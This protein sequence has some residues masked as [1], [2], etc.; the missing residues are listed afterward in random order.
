M[1]KD[2]QEWKTRRDR[3]DVKLKKAGWDV[4][5]RTKVLEEVDTK[6]SVFPHDI[7]HQKDTL[8]EEE[9]EKAYADYILLDNRGMPLA[10]VEAKKAYKDPRIG[11]KQAEMYVDDIK[12][13]LESKKDVLIFYTNGIDIWYWNKG[14]ETPRLVSGFYSQDDLMRVRFQNVSAENFLDVQPREE[15]I[16]RPYQLEA[17]QRVIE[18]M[19]RGK[20]RFLI[21]QATG[22]GKTRVA[23]ALI[24]VMIRAK[25]AKRILFLTDRTELNDQA[26]DEN[27][28][29][30]FPSESKQKV[31]SSTV[32]QDSRIYAATLQTMKNNYQ[33]FSVGFFDLIIS[34]EAHRSVYD[35][36]GSVF[37]YFDAKLIGLTATPADYVDHYTYEKFDCEKNV[38][39]FSFDY[40]QAVPK[41]LA[42]YAVWQAQT[43]IQRDGIDANAL[44]PEELRRL[45]VDE[46]LDPDDVNWTGSDLERKITVKSTIKAMIREF[47]DNCYEDNAGL[48]AK[49]IFFPVSIAHARRIEECFDEMYPEHHGELVSVIT[50]DNPR[51]KQMVKDF[52]KK[53][54]PRIA[55]SVGILDTGVDIPEVCNLAFMRPIR[56]GIRF[57]QML[58]RGTRHE[59]ICDHRDWLPNGKKESFL[60]FDYWQN[61]EEHKLHPTGPKMYKT[62]AI[63]TKIFLNRLK[64]YRK[65]FDR[66]ETENLE[67]IKQKIR[68]D[69]DNLDKESLTIQKNEPSIEITKEPSFWGGVGRDPIDFLKKEIAPLMKYRE[70]V[71]LP[72]QTFVHN[73]EKYLLVK[74]EHDEDPDWWKQPT[75][76]QIRDRI[77]DDV[78]K[79]PVNMNE[80]LPKADIIESV[81]NPEFWTDTKT[82]DIFRMT[83]ELRALMKH[84][85]TEAQKIIEIVAD[86]QIVERLPIIYGPDMKEERVEVYQ[87]KVE[88]RVRELADSH[89]VIQKIKTNQALTEK[90]IESLAEALNAPELFI[91]EEILGRIYRRPTG[92]VVEFIKHILGIE[93][94]KEPQELIDEAFRGF[95][96]THTLS[97][98]QL[99]F[100]QILQTYFERKRHVEKGDL[101]EFPFANMGSAW[102]TP[103]FK[104]GDVD[105]MLQMCTI[106]EKEVFEKR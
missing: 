70:G 66:N 75:A 23:M 58:G 105:N 56:S 72:E 101:Y 69:I 7:K 49:T 44:T 65:F 46:G 22:T 26:F 42:R 53:S 99:K 37:E 83:E 68:T 96:I 21:V 45:L 18:G 20:R 1:S 36:L 97:A 29:N 67:V 91:S 89:P 30:F 94:L 98:D 28:V 41:Y 2:E 85:R 59:S 55:I 106:L 52:K 104:E 24:D 17:V 78:L 16:N 88:R 80:V 4:K 31:Y 102:P 84:K 39:T 33:D 82:E 25:R 43:G 47:M 10:V 81:K 92:E 103:S 86:D 51:K 40:E 57:W 15:I 77:A 71:A 3:I 48:P 62:E 74:V 19:E 50:H 61:F 54:L 12:K 6:N 5:D 27:I 64:L 76:I 8:S 11:K 93:K 79:L 14:F 38:P 32:D 34:D 95:A 63:T 100:M 35:K 73:C 13:N 9:L 60:I 87:K 90:D